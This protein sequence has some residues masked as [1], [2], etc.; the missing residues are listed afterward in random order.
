MVHRKKVSDV[1]QKEQKALLFGWMSAGLMSFSVE[2]T[3][4]MPLPPGQ[5]MLNFKFQTRN[6]SIK[7]LLRPKTAVSGATQR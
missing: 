4:R 2:T 6:E 3:F 1:S 7:G 5:T